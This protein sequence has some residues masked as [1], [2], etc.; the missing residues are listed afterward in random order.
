M[1]LPNLLICLTL[2]G[3]CGVEPPAL[4]TTPPSAELQSVRIAYRS[5]EVRD[6]SLPDY[7][8]G[9]D[10]YV[11]GPDRALRPLDTVLWGDDP[12]R[13]VTL[14][15]T[16]DLATISGAQVASSPWPLAE[17]PQAE[18]DVRVEEFVADARGQFRMSGQ[19]FVAPREGVGR[20]RA[21][22]FALSAPVPP[23]AG[24][25]GFAAARSAVVAQLAELIARDGLR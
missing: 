20:D 8:A 24:P 25:L 13:A 16:R 11:E 1:R 10:V 6:V 18:L 5:V 9:E 4:L 19:Y 21:G 2:L 14:Q 12:E 17:F 7:A 3:A 22:V 15:L 23:G